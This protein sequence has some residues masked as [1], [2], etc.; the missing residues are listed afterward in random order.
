MKKT[1]IGIINKMREMDIDRQY[2]ADYI[3][4]GLAYVNARFS[5]DSSWT[6]DEMYR[7]SV[8]FEIPVARLIDYFPPR[9]ALR[10]EL[11]L[12]KNLIFITPLKKP[13]PVIESGVSW[14]YDAQ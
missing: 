9:P 10:K 11:D 4:K 14:R 1:Y 13:E 12:D 3:G 2:L 7:L 6:L 8:L 5:G